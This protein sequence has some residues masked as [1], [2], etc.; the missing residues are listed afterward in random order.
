MTPTERSSHEAP[1]ARSQQT[2][3]RL[4]E[5]S[6]RELK[7]HCYRMLGSIHEAEDLVQETFLR[8]W[9]SFDTFEHGTSMRAWLYRIATNACLN[10]LESRKSAQRLLPD[11]LGPA[12]QPVLPP[13]APAQDIAWLEPLPDSTLT[14]IA[15]EAPNPEAR[16][17]TREAVQLAFV[18][19]I[20]GLA[21]RQRAAL[22]LCDVLGWAAAEA[23]TLLGGSTAS[24]N[25]ALQRARETLGRRHSQ[26]RP[27]APQRPDPAQQALI[28][29][30]LQAWESHDLDGFVALL[31]EDATAVM[32]PWL[33]WFAGRE[34]IRSFFAI[35]WKVCGG[36]KLIATAANDQPAFAVYEFSPA[37]HHWHAHSI[38]VLSLEQDAISTLTLFIQPGLFAAFGLPLSLPEGGK[39]A[40]D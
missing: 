15:D 34:A 24:I 6:R 29:R 17:S 12:A 23:A 1:G 22:L 5:P 32:P 13:G 26:H 38:H 18:A 8:A 25:S 2:F 28:G 7:V 31:R 27:L 36:L 40:A 30:Y 37:D 20:Q 10:A 21:P 4:A 39:P 14:G 9:R 19:A 16:Y 33:Q 11:Q 3:E 35:A